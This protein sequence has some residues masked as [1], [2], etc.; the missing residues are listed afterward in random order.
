MLSII[1]TLIG[2]FGSILP[3]WFKLQ[4]SKIDHSHELEMYRLSM[5]AQK[6]EHEYKVEELNVNA[7]IAESQALYKSAEIHPSGFAFLDGLINLYNSSVRPTLTYLF[8]AFY[9][10]AKVGQYTYLIQLPTNTLSTTEMIWKLYNSEDMALFA[11]VVAYWFGQRGL[12]YAMDNFGRP[13]PAF[14]QVLTPV[15]P[16]NTPAA[17]GEPVNAPK[18]FDQ[19]AIKQ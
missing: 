18:A 15:D 7:D 12:R 4:Q 19:S 16:S 3:Q 9:G 2:F 5:E 6:A 10:L 11:T 1:G 14:S 8:F 17:K 13:K